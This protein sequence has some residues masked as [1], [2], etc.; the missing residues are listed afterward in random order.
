MTIYQDSDIRWG[1]NLV[2][3]ESQ[4]WKTVM[5]D[6]H[7]FLGLISYGQTDRLTIATEN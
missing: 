1:G 4:S 6:C 7:D 2:Q 5:D 3:P